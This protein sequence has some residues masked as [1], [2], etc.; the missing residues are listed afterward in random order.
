M[1]SPSFVFVLA[2][3]QRQKQFIYRF[4]VKAGV[5]PRHMRIE[6]SPSGEGSAEQWVRNNFARQARKCRA[7]NAHNSTGMLVVL[8]A[9]KCSVQ[10]HLSEL[11]AALAA[12][13]QP[14]L[15]PVS[16]PIARLI[17]KWSIETW[18]L[19]LSSN[20][21]SGAPISED[22]A[23]K[24]SRTE[25]QWNELISL[26]SATLYALSRSSAAL[27]ANL[28]DSLRCGLQEIPRA[29]PVER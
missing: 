28:I 2:E 6:V 16:D 26:A 3:D 9:D 27:P 19:F 5:G 20:G 23:Y 7:R 25:E 11:D 17:P 21:D 22:A 29:L 10:E 13:N 24:S 4:L 1:S 18:I 15:D 12:E 8:D 14:K